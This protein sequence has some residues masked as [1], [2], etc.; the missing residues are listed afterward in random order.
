M[1]KECKTKCQNKLQ[2]LKWKEQEKE[3]DQYVQDG[4][5]RLKRIKK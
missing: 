2:Q 1:L 4:E 3:E 5:M